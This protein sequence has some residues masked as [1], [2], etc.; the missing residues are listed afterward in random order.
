VTAGPWLIDKLFPV[1]SETGQRDT[2]PAGERY[3]ACLSK[4]NPSKW[5]LERDTGVVHLFPPGRD[6][7]CT[8]FDNIC[9]VRTSDRR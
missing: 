8:A 9:S 4:E 6:P 1:D 5:C 2:S 3:P 7:V